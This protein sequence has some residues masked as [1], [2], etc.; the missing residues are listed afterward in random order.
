M[1]EQT[2]PA[3]PQVDHKADGWIKKIA[4][5]QRLFKSWEKRAKAIAERYRDYDQVENSKKTTSDFN[6]LWSNI[7]VLMPATFARLPKPDVSRRWRDNDPVGRVA[8]L[9]LERALTFEVEHYPDYK[10]AMTNSVLDRFLGGRGT[11]WVR[12][13]PH[14][15]QL[16]PAENLQVTDDADEGHAGEELAEEVTYECAP[17]DYVHWRDFGHMPARTWEEVSGIWRNTYLTREKLVE[18]FGPEGERVPLDKRPESDTDN[19]SK[20]AGADLGSL[21]H[22]VEIW[23]KSTSSVLWLSP[24]LCR[25]MDERADPLGLENFWPC[26]R[27][28]FATTTTDNLVPVPD[29][30][31]YQD[32]ARQLNKLAARIDGLIDMLVVKGVYDGAIPELARLFKEAGNGDLIAVKNFQGFAEKA[33]LKGAIDIFD[34][35]PIV[36]ALTVAYEGVEKIKNEIYELMGVSDIARGASDPNETFGAQK[37]KGQYGNMRLRSKQDEVV[38]FATDLLKIKA[39]IM[40]QHFQ[41]QTF[42]KI[43]AADQLMPEDQQLVPQALQLLMGERA[44]NPDA[45]TTDGP[46]AAFRIEV[47]SDSMVQMDEQQEKGERLEFIN[48]FTGFLEKVVPA[49]KDNPQLAPLAVSMLKFGVSGFKVG[50]TMEGMIDQMLDQMVKA[51]S[52]PQPEKPDPEMQKIQAQMQ[53]E[54]KKLQNAMQ[55]GQAKTQAE[56]ALQ[57]NEQQQQAQQNAHQNSLEAERAQQQAQMD[58]ALEQQRMQFDH[59][60]KERDGANAQA[61]EAMRGQIQTLIAAMNNANK[62]EVAEIASQTTLE[63]AQVSAAQAA[64]AG[65]E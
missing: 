14:F 30:K 39:Q 48:T 43:A 28:L 33:G 42:L 22:I 54:D 37:L 16:A 12:Y 58:A 45:E 38:D 57:A 61:L 65:E 47:S 41:P 49:V 13:E 23:D 6:I 46:L 2:T 4:A 1:A 10:A 59:Q 55:L 20:A 50:K 15:S 44:M 51:A 7:Q 40:C 64:T 17:V 24:S 53:L 21:G 63:A 56:A 32:Q 29:Y 26:P 34:I 19:E 8:A 18:R 35:S 52:Q 27:P 25:I 5:Y 60:L 9:L 11:S 62:L 3:A 31:M 36:A